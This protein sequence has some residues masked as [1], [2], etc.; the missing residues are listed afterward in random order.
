MIII[1]LIGPGRIRKELEECQ[2]DV[3]TSGVSA[4]ARHEG[5]LDSLIGTIRGP[6]GT[7]YANGLFLLEINIPT[8]YP[9]EP[10][11]IR[12]ETKIWHPNISSQTGA[13]CLVRVCN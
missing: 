2:K 10:P 3:E 9:F 12:F 13:I 11:K 1:F 5:V 7:P 4:Y 8:T 6:E